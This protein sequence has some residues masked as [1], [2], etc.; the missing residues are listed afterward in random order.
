MDHSITLWL[1]PARNVVLYSDAVT[2]CGTIVWFG[3][4]L[5]YDVRARLLFVYY[6]WVRS[7]T[8]CET[9]LTQHHSNNIAVSDY[10]HRYQRQM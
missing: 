10:Q 2:I 7:A 5:W 8:K 3:Y 6:A 4:H 1:R 9:I